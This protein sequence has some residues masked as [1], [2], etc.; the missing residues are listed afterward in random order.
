MKKP[1]LKLLSTFCCVCLSASAVLA[2]PSIS[3]LPDQILC[4][5]KQ[6]F[7]AISRSG[8][9]IVTEQ[10]WFNGLATSLKI[11][12]LE[13]I[14][15]GDHPD[16]RGWYKAT[17]QTPID[18]PTVVGM[19]KQQADVIEAVPNGL[20]YFSSSTP[21][22]TQYPNQWNL[23]HIKMPEAW[24][25]TS[26]SNQIIVAIIDLC[27]RKTQED[28]SA[29]LWEN[30][31]E[32]VNNMDDDGNGYVD[33]I[34]GVQTNTW[35][36]GQP[37]DF[38]GADLHG[39][40]VASVCCARTNNAKGIAGIAGG[41]FAGAQGVRI[42]FIQVP[43]TQDLNTS[44]AAA[45]ARGV[46]YAR[47]KGAQVVNMSLEIRTGFEPMLS[48]IDIGVTSGRN[49]LGV[50]YTA[51]S[52][53]VDSPH[54]PQIGDFVY[55]AKHGPVLAVG[56]IGQNGQWY[57]ESNYEDWLDVVAP[58]ENIWAAYGTGDSTYGALIGTSF[59]APHAAGLA[60]L[61]LSLNQNLTY[62]QVHG[63]INLNPA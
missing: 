20:V 14:F 42:M 36:T 2:Q 58:G 37:Q 16:L 63:I 5:I 29:Q 24:D 12:E 47:L 45:V 23:P 57:Y 59:A 6:P 35:N 7:T 19:F 1:G 15:A 27:C 60:A 43:V 8:S 13:T 34:N 3:Y 17:Y 44:D 33:D 53:N 41:G 38:Y 30:P 56:S 9:I 25:I 48:E 26:G 40:L 55:P 61:I 10:T 18:V 28:L 31:N 32:I 51:A 11:V 46:E 39:T 49:T 62:S 4:K 22:D 54:W 50:V 52:G 21:S